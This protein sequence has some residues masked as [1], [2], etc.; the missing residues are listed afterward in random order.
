MMKA[1]LSLLVLLAISGQVFGGGLPGRL[2]L[3]AEAPPVKGPACRCRIV[4]C[5]GSSP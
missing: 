1:M 3:T 5:C 4:S 2:S